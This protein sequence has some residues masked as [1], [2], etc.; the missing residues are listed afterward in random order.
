MEKKSIRKIVITGGP[1]SG[2]SVG[3]QALKMHY[4]QL[5][6]KVLVVP[7]I[8][9]E[10]ILGGAD[11]KTCGSAAVFQGLLFGLQLATEKVFEKA[12]AA[13]EAEKVII[14]LDRGTMDNKAYLTEEEFQ[15]LLLAHKTDESALMAAYDAVIHLQTLAKFDP[16]AYE[17]KKGG[18]PARGETAEEAIALDDRLIA[19]WSGHPNFR[20]VTFGREFKDKLANLTA[21]I[22][23]CLQ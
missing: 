4:R 23:S 22:S 13:C 20:V 18:N 19:A 5:G 6:Y 10:M 14:F 8:A 3:M 17:R 7:E 12:A 11:L 1:C 9:S 2:K 21:E 15:Q 16:E